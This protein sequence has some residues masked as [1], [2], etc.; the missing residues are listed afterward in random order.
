MPMEVAM[1]GTSLVI[2][3]ALAIAVI[4]HMAVDPRVARP[5]PRDGDA[6]P[7]ASHPTW[8]AETIRGLSGSNPSFHDQ[9][10]LTKPERLP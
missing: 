1:M 7:D 10:K 5:T 8:W 3:C 9:C 2:V 6:E 4:G